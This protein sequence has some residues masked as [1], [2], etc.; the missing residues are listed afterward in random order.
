MV[1]THTAGKSIIGKKRIIMNKKNV[2]LFLKTVISSQITGGKRQSG[3]GEALFTV[4]A[5]LPCYAIFYFWQ[6]HTIDRA[7]S[8]R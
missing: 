4:R 5:H 1:H 7:C 6:G 3:E 2:V 8:A